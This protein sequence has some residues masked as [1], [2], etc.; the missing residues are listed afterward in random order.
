MIPVI[1]IDEDIKKW[2][3]EDIPYW[4]VTTSLLPEG[5]AEGKIYSKQQGTVAGLFVVKRI[6]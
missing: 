6:F 5:K 1:I 3:E 4:D 2:I